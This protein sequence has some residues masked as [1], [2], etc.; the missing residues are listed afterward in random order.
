MRAG[1][2]GC[3]GPDGNDGEA[4]VSRWTKRDCRRENL[5]TG[6]NLIKF[7]SIMLKEFVL[8]T[9]VPPPDDSDRRRDR[10]GSARKRRSGRDL[11][12]LGA[13]YDGRSH[14]Q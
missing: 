4:P 12:D 2:A 6:S 5:H 9:T 1:S 8:Q 13:P 11:P 3:H 14:G 7:T 10:I